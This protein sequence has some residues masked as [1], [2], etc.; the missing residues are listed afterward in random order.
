MDEY[1]ICK[2]VLFLEK[3]LFMSM[4]VMR[5][6]G[7]VIIHLCMKVAINAVAKKAFRWRISHKK[8]GLPV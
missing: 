7:V 6:D 5:T 1:I 8:T 3:L 4:R 2:D